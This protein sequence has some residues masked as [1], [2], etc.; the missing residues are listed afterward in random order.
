MMGYYQAMTIHN[1]VITSTVDSD[2]DFI[3][4]TWVFPPES[5]YYG[6]LNRSARRHPVKG[7]PDDPDRQ[8]QRQ[9][10]ERAERRRKH[11][12]H[13]RSRPW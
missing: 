6:A 9:G 4:V 5:D 10:Q 13:L 2:S 3:G 11:G 7:N 8:K 12:Q 1:T